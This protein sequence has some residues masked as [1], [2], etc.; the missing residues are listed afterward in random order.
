[1]GLIFNFDTENEKNLVSNMNNRS[2]LYYNHVVN[3]IHCDIQM[4]EFSVQKMKNEIID[5]CLSFSMECRLFSAVSAT[6]N[7]ATE[8]YAPAQ[9]TFISTNWACLTHTRACSEYIVTIAHYMFA[10]LF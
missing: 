7:V 6:S 1:M 4:T 5:F 8:T 3:L 9:Q 2:I 10:L